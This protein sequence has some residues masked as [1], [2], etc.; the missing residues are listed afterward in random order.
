LVKKCK[1]SSSS[2]CNVSI[3]LLYSFS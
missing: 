1:L 3:L 2:L